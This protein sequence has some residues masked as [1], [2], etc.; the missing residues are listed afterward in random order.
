MLSRQRSTRPPKTQRWSNQGQEDKEI[1]DLQ[2]EM[3]SFQQAINRLP[4]QGSM[5]GIRAAW[6][7][8]SERILTQ[9]HLLSQRKERNNT[10][11]DPNEA[12]NKRLERI[13]KTLQT[14]KPK[15][16]TYAE[17]LRTNNAAA[18]VNSIIIPYDRIGFEEH[19]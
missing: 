10:N 5:G 3:K 18:Q 1:E 15:P 11:H 4:S 6:G 8:L 14:L 16:P 12:I 2:N 9:L 19:V 7:P 13:E 17:A